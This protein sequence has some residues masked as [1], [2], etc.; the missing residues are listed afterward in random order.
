MPPE[1]LR[2]VEAR[3]GRF[4]VPRQDIYVGRSLEVYGEWCETEIRIAAQ[5]I[6]PGDVIVDAGANIGTHSVAFARMAG[7]KGRV[8]AIEAQPGMAQIVGANALLNGLSNIVPLNVG[9]ADAP[10]SFAIGPINY[11][12][13]A[14]FGGISIPD[15]DGHEDAA[16]RIRVSLMPLDE[17]V[18]LPRLSFFKLDIEHME[19]QAL[20]GARQTIARC[21]PVIYLENSDPVET[22]A[23]LAELQTFGYR[24]FWHECR[25]FAPDNWRGNAEN[26]F[27]NVSC[28]NMLCVPEGRAVQGLTPATGP[29]THPRRRGR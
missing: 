12:A 10:G 19:A 29:E 2:L 3:H 23:I 6:K 20:R 22:S 18:D 27:E 14:N 21:L 1:H 25:L 26:I 15:L 5:V 28:V 9:L 11:G 7:P 17:L 8:Y 16:G 24:A 13:N 4:L